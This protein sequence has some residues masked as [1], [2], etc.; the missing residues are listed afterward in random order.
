M[1]IVCNSLPG[2]AAVCAAAIVLLA[3]SRVSAPASE[4]GSALVIV[5]NKST[6]TMMLSA[7]DVKQ[8]YLGE[9]VR[10]PDGKKVVVVLLD[11]NGP[12]SRVMLKVI[13]GMSEREYKRYLMQADF[14]GKA[15]APPRMLESAAAV[16][17]FVAST[18]GAVGYVRASDSD[19][20]VRA[21]KLDGVAAGSAGYK[22]A[23]P[24]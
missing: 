12:D 20:S 24:Q 18:P 8:M 14:A 6:F 11:A 13:L 16:K 1:R 5:V 10:W 2:R 23:L 4:S 22:L 15:V 9:R 19:D 21:V 3:S 7:N 17:Q